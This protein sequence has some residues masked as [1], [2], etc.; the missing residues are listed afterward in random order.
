MRHFLLIFKRLMISKSTSLSFWNCIPRFACRITDE[1][2]ACCTMII[3]RI[4][5]CSENE[6]PPSFPYGYVG[7]SSQRRDFNDLHIW[8]YSQYSNAFKISKSIV[9]STKMDR[10]WIL[11]RVSFNYSCLETM[12]SIYY[13][14]LKLMNS[15]E[16]LWIAKP[17]FEY[18]ILP[19]EARQDSSKLGTLISSLFAA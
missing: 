12:I 16:L 14:F 17:V 10:S 13:S 1:S 7:K 3:L 6:H 8:F 11:G 9:M 5:A 15:F 18:R 4:C 2:R 19:S